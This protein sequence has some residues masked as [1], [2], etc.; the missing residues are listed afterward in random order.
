M[1]VF[2]MS[3][4]TLTHRALLRSEAAIHERLMDLRDQLLRLIDA[5]DAMTLPRRSKRRVNQKSSTAAGGNNV[6]SLARRFLERD[7]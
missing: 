4:E 7:E 1:Y 5:I 6:V 2:F 3:K